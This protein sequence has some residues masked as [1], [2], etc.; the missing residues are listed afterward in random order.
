MNPSKNN[1]PSPGTVISSN[2]SQQEAVS[3]NSYTSPAA[4]NPK[5]PLAPAQKTNPNSTQNLL[6]IAEIRDGIVIMDDGSYRSVIMVKPINFDLMS[7]QERE[8]VEFAYQSFLNSLYF[9]VQI[10]IHS[11]KVDLTPYLQRLDKIRSEQDNMLLAYLMDDYINFMLALSQQTNIM[12]KRFYI[13]VPYYPVARVQQTITQSKNF[14]TGISHLFSNKLTHV[15]IDENELTKAKDELKN[16]V[17]ALLNALQQCGIR[18]LPLDT[19]ELIEL[20]YN[21]YNPDTATRQHLQNFDDLNATVVSKGEGP[22]ST[23]QLDRE[24]S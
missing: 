23:P 5:T 20:Y 4:N 12:D 15:T 22:A 1:Q 7:G 6:Q 14:F 18:G 8:A 21:T 19:Q 2:S 9:P 11:E 3:G 10:F 17:E 16:R 24:L 13:V